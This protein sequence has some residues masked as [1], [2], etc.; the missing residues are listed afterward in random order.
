M[1]TA[2]KYCRVY[3]MSEKLIDKVCVPCEGGTKP[4]GAEEAGKLLKELNAGPLSGGNPWHAR[5]DG[6]TIIK[7][8]RFSDFTEARAAVNIVAD[9]AEAEDHHPD[10]EW[11]YSTVKITLWTHA[12]DGLSENDFIL[13]AKIEQ[14]LANAA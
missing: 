7:E 10:I 8:F 2:P 6:K 13:A 14:A 3:M 5:D 9:A 4:L 11:L 1:M 12:I